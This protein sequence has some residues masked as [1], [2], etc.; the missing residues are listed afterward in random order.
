MNVFH[1]F[2]YDASRTYS[3]ESKTNVGPFA[4][5]WLDSGAITGNLAATEAQ[6]TIAVSGTV[7]A[8]TVTGMLASTESGGDTAAATGTVPVSGVLA[9]AETS[10]DA[11]AV[12][13]V[14]P[15]SG[16][17]SATEQ[18]SD[19]FSATAG[20]DVAG[21]SAPGKTPFKRRMGV[22]TP[23]ATG[24]FTARWSYLAPTTGA[25]SIPADTP[26]CRG[27][28]ATTSA[29]PIPWVGHVTPLT[30]AKL[31]V[32]TNTLLPNCAAVGRVSRSVALPKYKLVYPSCGAR[33]G[34]ARQGATGAFSLCEPRVVRNPSDAELLALI[35]FL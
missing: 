22:T 33:L 16:F 8:N 19:T 13:G 24:E 4:L 2:G 23:P 34:V 15:I 25:L 14:V 18:T 20:A 6:D 27:V 5:V 1:L 21:S 30:Q 9:V 7:T 17:A 31:H 11:I 29:S 35:E 3:E 26:Y 32:G 28:G 10:A 12:A